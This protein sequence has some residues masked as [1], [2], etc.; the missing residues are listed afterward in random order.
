MSTTADAERAVGGCRPTEG[1]PVTINAEAIDSTADPYLQALKHELDREGLVPAEVVVKATFD[2]DCSFTTQ[3]EADRI[4]EYLHAADF[5]GA[6]TLTLEIAAVA[7]DT[8]VQPAIAALRE[9]AHRDGITLAVE[10]DEL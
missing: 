8:K 3:S 10:T 9:R 6:G 1:T 4:R 7:D 5:L 2:A